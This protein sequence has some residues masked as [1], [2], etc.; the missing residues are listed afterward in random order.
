[1]YMALSFMSDWI[2][3]SSYIFEGSLAE[4]LRFECV[5]HAFW[6]EVAYKMSF[7]TALALVIALVP[8][9]SSTC[10][11]EGSL[12]EWLRFAGV[13][14]AL[15]KEVSYKM[16]F[17]EIA[18]ARN[19]EF[20]QYK[21]WLRTWQVKLCGTTVA[22]RPRIILGSRSNRPSIV[23]IEFSHVSCVRAVDGNPLRFATP[24]W[25]SHCKCNCKCCW[26]M[27][28]RWNFIVFCSFRIVPVM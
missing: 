17:R 3:S 25:F 21:G 22:E 15:W 8:V 2:M 26:W 20:F 19:A 16:R 1:M 23:T 7:S 12:A 4:W 13:Q 9:S 6:K 5:Q 27:S 10:I 11:L 14:R 24:G 28:C 18:H